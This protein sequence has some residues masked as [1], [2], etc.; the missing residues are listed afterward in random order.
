MSVRLQ[1]FES[2]DPCVAYFIDT[3]SM[4][5]VSR[6]VDF[7]AHPMD[8]AAHPLEVGRY[9]SAARVS[10]Y[11]KDLAILRGRSAI[12]PCSS[13]IPDQ[14]TQRRITS[15]GKK[16]IGIGRIKFAPS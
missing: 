8:G 13:V 9:S 12:Y 10:D 7:T 6:R 5:E 15:Q 2:V 4:D 14:A 3:I 16:E 11:C 1:R